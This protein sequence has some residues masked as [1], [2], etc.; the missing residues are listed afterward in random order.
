MRLTVFILF[1]F[2]FGSASWAQD[3]ERE[4]RWKPEVVGNLVVG[5]AV[6]L[7]LPSGR[8]FLGLHA[9]GKPGMPAVVIVHGSG[10]HPDHGVI[11]SLRVA[12]ADMGY[13]TLSIQMPV[14][15]ADTPAAEYY[16]KLFPEA[17]ERIRA[18]EAWLSNKGLK[19]QVLVSH[20]LGAWMSQE[21]LQ[22]AGGSPF[23]GYVSMGRSGPLPKLALPVLD[24]YGEKDFPAVLESAPARRASVQVR[25]AGAD[26]FYNGREAELAAV[27][28]DFISGL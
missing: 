10:V 16:P 17:G 27:L 26:H 25:I 7:R 11:G 4:A 2:F 24:V 21:Y 23:A 1:F 20:S 5:D 3:Y 19:K 22:K 28:K 15:A 13:T 12:L 8:S 6:D 9:Q 14:L 18:A